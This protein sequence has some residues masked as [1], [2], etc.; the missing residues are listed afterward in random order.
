VAGNIGGRDRH[1]VD[2]AIKRNAAAPAISDSI[3]NM[4]PLRIII[5][6]FD[7][8][9]SR[10][11]GVEPFTDDPQCILRIQAGRIK[12]Q[13]AFPEKTIPSNSPA[14]FLHFWNERMPLIPAKGPD[15]A[16]GLKFQR[17]ILHS[18]RLIAKHIQDHPALND[19]QAVGGVTTFISRQQADGGRAAFQHLGFTIFPYHRPLGA[20][21]EFW[22][23]FYGWWL[24]WTYNPVSARY[25]KMLEMQHTEFWMT[26]EKFMERFGKK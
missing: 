1:L 2:P 9:L 18:M 24:M 17:L 3:L 11:E 19:I 13:I 23:N 14:L 16:Y 6:R 22:E 8:W 21:G 20:F 10:M 4:N 15:L 7:N 25:R 5:R 12:H 26:K